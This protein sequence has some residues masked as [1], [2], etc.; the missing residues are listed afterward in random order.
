MSYCI[1][2]SQEVCDRTTTHQISG[3]R[4]LKRALWLQRDNI[5]SVSRHTN[6]INTHVL[7]Q[8]FLSLIVNLCLPVL[9]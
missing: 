5:D 7:Q 6:L 4:G 3:L 2:L 9:L 1:C 8:L